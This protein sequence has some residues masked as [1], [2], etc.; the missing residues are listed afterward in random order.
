MQTKPI[1]RFC[2]LLASAITVAILAG[3]NGSTG[4]AGAPGANAPT[5]TTVS[6]VIDA[7]KLSTASWIALNPVSSITSVN[8]S[9]AQG[10]PVVNF[11]VT[12]PNGTGIVGLENFSKLDPTK[13]LTASY[14]NFTFT[15]AK[16]IPAGGL[17]SAPVANAPSKWVNYMV[18]SVP[19]V[20]HP[21]SVP[22]GPAWKAVWTE[23]PPQPSA[24]LATA[25]VPIPTPSRPTSPRSQRP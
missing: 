6:S 1:T 4:P 24:W 10:R 19:N 23:A 14:P 18:M 25:T 2:G 7:S 13:D 5:T 8:V 21:T 17:P 11:K 3:C 22:Q 12:D 20:A 16:L 15:I 9:A